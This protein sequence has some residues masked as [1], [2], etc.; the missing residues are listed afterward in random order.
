MSSSSEPGNAIDLTGSQ[1]SIIDD[2]IE[3]RAKLSLEH[4]RLQADHR[5]APHFRLEADLVHGLDHAD[6]VERV[7]ADHQQIRINRLDRPHDRG[8][9]GGGWRIALFVDDLEARRLAFSCA[10]SQA[11][12]PNSASAIV[13]AIVCGFGF[14]ASATLKKPRVKAGF[15]VGPFG[16]IE[17]YLGIVERLVDAGAKKT[18]EQF[19]LLNRDR[20]RGGDL[21]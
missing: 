20:H 11:L 9:I 21:S 7:R 12:R 17:K 15:G 13:I 14:C 4:R 1:V 18:H 6:G 16:I 10:P 3:H 8:E 5:A 19:F 2:A